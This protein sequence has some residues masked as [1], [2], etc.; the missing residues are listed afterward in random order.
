VLARILATYAK[1]ASHIGYVQG[2]NFICGSLLYH[3]SEEAAFWMFVMIMEDY[4]LEEVYTKGLPGLYRHTSMIEKLLSAQKPLEDVFEQLKAHQIK[5][6]M[7]AT[8]WIFT[9]FTNIIP[10]EMIVLALNRE[11]SMI[12]FSA[13]HGLFSISFCFQF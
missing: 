12:N 8:D 13:S 7:F 3:C 2:M 1:Y 10:I 9:L 4:D 5:A 11:I 6:D